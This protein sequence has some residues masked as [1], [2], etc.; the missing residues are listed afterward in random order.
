MNVLD[1]PFKQA[2]VSALI[3]LIC[4]AL[5]WQLDD[6]SVDL[7]DKKAQ[8]YFDTTITQAGMAY[9]TTRL[10]NASVSVIM[11]SNLQ[12]QPAGIGLSLAIGQVLDP[13]NDMAERL[14]DVLVMAIVSLGVQKLIYEISITAVPL[15]LAIVLTLVAILGFSG[16]AK[17]LL[18]KSFCLRLGVL[19]LLLRLCLPISAILNDLMYQHFYKEAITDAKKA[20]TAESDS[21]KQLADFSHIEP[22]AKP[23]TQPHKEQGF[24]PQWMQGNVLDDTSDF[25]QQKSSH[26]KQAFLSKKQYSAALIEH[27]LTL[28]YLYMALFLIQVIFLPTALFYLMIRLGQALKI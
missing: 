25:L 13:L 28:T 21:I 5:L 14:S 16:H 10:I 7:L 20:L 23:Q 8:S 9:G 1:T 27:L 4:A 24:F 19:L 2:S 17:V 11:E 12:L 18:I 6:L 3:C 15:L 26:F 22:K